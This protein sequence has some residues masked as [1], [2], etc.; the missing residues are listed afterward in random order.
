MKALK[1][2]ALV[3][4]SFIGLSQTITT[5]IYN[6]VTGHKGLYYSAGAYCAYDTLSNW[7]CGTPCIKNAGLTGVV[8]ILNSVRNTF[9]YVG[10]NAN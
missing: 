3:I 8:K 5:P 9:A 2:A 4:A 6:D 7:Q 1:L 10:Y